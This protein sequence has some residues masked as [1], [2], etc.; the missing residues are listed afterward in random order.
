MA[1]QKN[2]RRGV[3]PARC[4]RTFE[5]DPIIDGGGGRNYKNNPNYA[6]SQLQILDFCK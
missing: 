2:I 6:S 1:W 5:G 4:D 3:C